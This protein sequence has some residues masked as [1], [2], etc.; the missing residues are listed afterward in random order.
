MLTA[1]TLKE[2]ERI[3][4]IIE[5]LGISREAVVI[6]LRPEHPGR[7]SL[8]KDGK[9]HI[10]VESEGDFEQWLTTAAGQIR[11]LLNRGPG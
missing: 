6:P 10:V 5:P 8:S 1:V 11:A 9:L 7:V 2:I 4:A 3:F